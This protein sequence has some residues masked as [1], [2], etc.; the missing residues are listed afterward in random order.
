MKNKI[1]FLIFIFALEAAAGKAEAVCPVCTVAVG[2]GVGLSRWLGISDLITGLWLGA[3][4]LSLALW[5]VDWLGKR[6]IRSPFAKFAVIL[7]G[8]AMAIVPLYYAEI[9]AH[10]IDFLRSATQDKLILG[11]IEGSAV[12]FFAA[13]LYEFLKERN[14]G[15]AHFPFEKIALPVIFL[16]FFSLAFHFI[17][18]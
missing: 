13:K 2:A 17:T 16:L 7:A 15:R 9:T 6:K 4:L 1:T 12:F 14:N 11:I 10:P 18:R 3:F 8:Y 5:A